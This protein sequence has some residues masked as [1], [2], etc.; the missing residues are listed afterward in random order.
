[1]SGKND[2]RYIAFNNYVKPVIKENTFQNWVLNGKKNEFYQ[3]IIDRNNGSPTNSSINTTYADL[4]FGQGLTIKDEEGNNALIDILKKLI[5]DADLKAICTDFQLFNEFSAQIIKTKERGKKLESISHISKNLVVPSVEDD[6]MNILSYWF[7]RDWKNIYKYIP[8][9][10]PAFPTGKGKETEIYR[11]MPYVAGAK[12]YPNPDYLSG[13]QYSEVEEEI[14]NFGLRHIKN[15]FSWGTVVNVPNSYDWS[16]EDKNK[17]E[18]NL[19]GGSTG[20]TNAGGM[21]VAF[22]GEGTDPITVENI[23]NNTAHK[24]WDSLRTNA[25]EQILT[26]HRCTS[27]SIV[28]VNTSSGFSST[29]EEMETARNQLLKYVI[30]PKQE[31]IIRCLKEILS[32]YGIDY[33]I[34]FL[35][36]FEVEEISDKA[37]ENIEEEVSLSKKKD[38]FDLFLDMGETVDMEQYDLI[39]EGNVDY[40]E[41]VD[42]F[43]K[44]DFAST[45]VARPNSKSAQDGEDYI[46]RY[47]YTGDKTGERKFCGKMLAADKV[48]RK[49]DILQMGTKNVNPGFGMSPTPNKPY[50]IWLYKGGGLLSKEFP[51]GT[52]KHKWN[53]VIYLKK[54]SSV[55]VNSPLAKTISTSEARRKGLKVPVNNPKVGITPNKMKI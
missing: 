7:S 20:S 54:G 22:L 32:S 49:E 10:Y 30:Q 55:D 52:C 51:N 15:G 6:E 35:P 4:I 37:E 46:I 38:D 17:Y 53:R 25:R 27:S 47:K 16:T 8:V 33:D 41:E 21:V 40:E 44:L 19:Q 3:Y 42:Q 26:S 9:N 36:F 34:Y 28:G 2:I 5:P 11:G 12:Y 24:Q 50:S 18:K 45:G 43:G 31:F 23:E 48:Y 13:L 14:S 1:M 39:D 29:A